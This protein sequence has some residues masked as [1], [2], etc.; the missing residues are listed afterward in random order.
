MRWFFGYFQWQNPNNFSNRF[1]VDTCKSHP[2]S[3]RADTEQFKSQPG[4]L[5]ISSNNSWPL[6]VN[7]PPFRKTRQ[8]QNSCSHFLQ[9]PKLFFNIFSHFN[10]LIINLFPQLTC[11]VSSPHQYKPIYQAAIFNLF[12]SLHFIKNL[13]PKRFPITQKATCHTWLC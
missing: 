8:T 7:Y 11:F 4:L 13:L 2:V 1:I 3:L 10:T 6:L 9:G 12:M 5:C